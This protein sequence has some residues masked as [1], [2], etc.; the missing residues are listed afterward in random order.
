MKKPAPQ[1]GGGNLPPKAR[2]KALHWILPGVDQDDLPPKAKQQ[3]NCLQ[4]VAEDLLGEN[5]AL[6]EQVVHLKDTVCVLKGEKKRPLFKPSRMH[7]DA[8]KTTGH[9]PQAQDRAETGQE[10]GPE[11]Q[12][13]A[14]Q[15]VSAPEK[16]RRPG[17]D[18]ASKTASLKIDEDRI[19]K[20]AQAL[21]PGSIFKGYRH[22]HSQ[23]LLM[24]SVNIRYRLERWKGAISNPGSSPTCC[25][26]TTTATLPSRCCTSNCVN[27]ASLF[28]QGRSTHCC[29]T[30]RRGFMR[31][32]APF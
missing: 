28:R 10:P 11:G 29:R 2:T 27:G 25:T 30:A 4:S 7:Q 13:E 26:S 24:K 21:P 6:R 22:F 16:P 18:K 9:P 12:C 31:R 20:P 17:S 15:A 8:G 1:A 5:I 19:I 14:L 3:V 23:D 32:R